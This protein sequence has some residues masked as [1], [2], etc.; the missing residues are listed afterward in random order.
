M[1]SRRVDPAQIFRD[2]ATER[3]DN[4]DA[5]LLAVEAG[6]AG[7]GTVDALF[8][9]AHTIKGAAGML[10]LEDVRT[11]AHAVE[12]VLETVRDT[13]LFPP[14]LA[15]TLM[16]ATGALRAQITGSGEAAPDIVADLVSSRVALLAGGTAAED[17]E[18]WVPGPRDATQPQ[19][20]APGA[21]P[22]GEGA[23]GGAPAA[24][25]EAVPAAAGPA[26]TPSA[27]GTAGTLPGDGPAPP[28]AGRPAAGPAPAAAPGL[29]PSSTGTSGD[30]SPGA[31]GRGQVRTALR[32]PAEQHSLRVPA[33]KID[34]LLDLVGEAVHDRRRLMHALG[35]DS[36]LSQGVADALGAGDRTL[37]E[38]KDISIGMRTLPLRTI[39]GPL[40][41]AVRDMAHAAGKEVEFVITGSQTELDRV[42]LES[43]PEP[44]T[45][46][47]RNAVSHGIETPAERERANKPRRGRIELRAVSRGSLVEITVIDDG[48]GVSQ[49]ALRQARTEGSLADVLARA[50]YSTAGE[51]S[52]L[53]G[54]GVGLDAVKIAVQSL[55]GSLS[56]YSEPGRGTEVVLLLPLALALLEVLLFERGGAAFGV[57]L[58]M[59]DVAVVVN[60][61][62]MLEG[63]PALDVRGHSLPVVDFAALAG[64]NAPALPDQP[65][66]LVI[67]AGGRRAI[68]ACDALLGQEEVVVKPLGPLLASVEGYLGAAI[69]GDGRI[70]LLVE[71]AA[72]TRARRGAALKP[73]SPRPAKAPKVLV[74]EDSFTVRELQRSILE[75][76]GY[77]V[78]TARHGREALALI[79]QD[80]EIAMV[81]TDLDMPE[82]DGLALTRAIRADP[83]RASL[84]VVIVTSRGS[85]EDRRRGIEAG[86]DAYMAKR[87]FDQRALLATVEQLV[88]R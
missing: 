66:G 44:L 83:A 48:K 16:A 69:L 8:R 29:V 49:A 20:G 73:P 33:D 39:A 1:S 30:R 68:V 72:L 85:D 61:T 41:R 54:R 26:G 59:V 75:T 6:E 46:I 12:D 52:D 5:G 42:I 15:G 56:V 31:G 79:R 34:H 40:P 60:D 74:A 80:A 62:F 18:T 84:P 87:S 65:P 50:G 10:G 4:M 58:A 2:E 22:D 7:A 27:A 13:G 51:V 45:H 14:D 63:R 70:A 35:E 43:L 55:G 36:Q 86:A 57:P 38:L 21:A 24:G 3:L 77:Q 11:L 23:P 32:S 47:L 71:P 25:P 28:P 53:A 67:S 81:V 9:N 76:A 88:G 37:E 82:L 19:A 17:T 64:A 78:V